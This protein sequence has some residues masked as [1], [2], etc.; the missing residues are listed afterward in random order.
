[1]SDGKTLEPSLL[2]QILRYDAETGKLF[3]LFRS[4]EMFRIGQQSAEHSAA[5]WNSRW[6]GT[7]ALSAVT[8]KGY[9]AGRIFGRMYYANRI[10]WAMQTGEWPKYLVDHRDTDRGNNRWENLRQA[11][12]SQNQCNKSLTSANSSG[13]KGVS[14]HKPTGKWQATISLHGSQ[15]HLGYFD[16]PEQA[17]HRVNAERCSLHR[18]FGRVA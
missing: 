17:G 1:M 15:R 14:L 13:F 3:W 7:E 5:R 16:S 8:A 10:V 4:P 18:E 2:H 6:A 11:T 9:R 12:H